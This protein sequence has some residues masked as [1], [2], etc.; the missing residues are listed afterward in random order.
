MRNYLT[1]SIILLTIISCSKED[2]QPPE[3]LSP[4]RICQHDMKNENNIH[5]IQG[6]LHNEYLDY[7]ESK[8]NQ[9][10]SDGTIDRGETRII[11]SEF[12]RNTYGTE[13]NKEVF[14]EL[15]DIYGEIEINKNIPGSGYFNRL[16]EYVPAIC[17]IL[18][19]TPTFPEFPFD[20]LPNSL[21]N[22]EN[23]WN[24]AYDKSI[25]SIKNLIEFEDDIIAK[26][27]EEESKTLLTM[28][29]VGRYSSGYWYNVKYVDK[30]LNNW[31][32]FEG[33]TAPCVTCDIIK[34]D[35]GGAAIGALIGGL[36]SLPGAGIA[37][38]AVGIEYGARAFWDWLTG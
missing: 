8:L 4:T 2:I 34:G 15:M 24:D 27:N 16:C 26:F 28:A 18:T 6:V 17:D 21:P 36:G 3:L 20:L 5:D 1:I 14:N 29:A 23:D 11:S 7:F 12:Y 9:I 25:K 30:T 13:M 32:D 38:A 35:V 22:D 10:A 37:S 19:P 33:A 31:G